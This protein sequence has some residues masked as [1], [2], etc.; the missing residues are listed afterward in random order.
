MTD[1]SKKQKELIKEVN[2]SIQNRNNQLANDIK[3]VYGYG[4]ASKE[5]RLKNDLMPFVVTLVM[6]SAIATKD[7]VKAVSDSFYDVVGMIDGECFI[8]RESNSTRFE[9]NTQMII[10]DIPDYSSF[11]YTPA[12]SNLTDG[13]NPNLTAEE[14]Y[15]PIQQ[16]QTQ[17]R[18]GVRESVIIFITNDPVRYMRF[19]R[20]GTNT[21]RGIA[22]VLAF[23]EPGART[24]SIPEVGDDLNTNYGLNIFLSALA[25]AL[26][27]ERYP[28]EQARGETGDIL[29]SNPGVQ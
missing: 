7:R 24:N 20:S 28:D 2:G 15:T 26:N 17:Q 10:E 13:I 4:D 1:S 6:D 25:S 18:F 21:R 22:A 23:M 8:K 16:W 11:D 27:N 3:R 12:H 29:G 14:R 9:G 19:L 5:K